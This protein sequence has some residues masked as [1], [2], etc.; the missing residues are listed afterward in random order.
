MDSGV[1]QSDIA[2]Q[3][4]LSR[5]HSQRRISTVYVYSKR[6]ACGREAERKFDYWY[7][8]RTRG[9]QHRRHGYG[10]Q[11]RYRH[12]N[13]RTVRIRDFDEFPSSSLYILALFVPSR[14]S[15]WDA[16]LCIFSLR[17]AAEFR[18]HQFGMA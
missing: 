8:D 4:D 18:A 11:Q 16:P 14:R 10:R 2:R 9:L 15:G 13:D 1:N 6:V 12:N 5:C 3:L 7:P 17:A